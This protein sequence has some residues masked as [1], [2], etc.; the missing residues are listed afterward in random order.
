[1]KT[2]KA[3]NYKQAKA[4]LEKLDIETSKVKETINAS[5]KFHYH[6]ALIKIINKP[7]KV[8]ND[9]TVMVQSFH[10]RGFEK[11]TKNFKN[12]G[13]DLCVLLHNPE[14]LKEE[15]GSKIPEYQKRRAAEEIKAEVEAEKQAEI[16]KRIAKKEKEL[17]AEQV[18]SETQDDAEV[19]DLSEIRAMNQERLIAYA[20]ENEIETGDETRVRQL[21]PIVIDWAKSQNE[22]AVKVAK[23]EAAAE[24]AAE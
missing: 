15:Q 13:F 23:K 20:K 12:N 8:K 22:E 6:I 14:K 5:D 1:M 19:V 4:E 24:K 7:G 2:I 16:A 17:E 11:A 9:T 3:N 18:E 10:K 21:L